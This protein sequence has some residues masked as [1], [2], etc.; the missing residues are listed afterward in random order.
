[1]VHVIGL[2]LQNIHQVAWIT[3]VAFLIHWFRLCI[4]RQ[5]CITA[6]KKVIGVIKENPSM[7]PMPRAKVVCRRLFTSTKFVQR[8]S[9][10]L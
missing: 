3:F 7:D 8:Y 5:F 4:K 10:Y 9:T 2:S 1:M 6:Y